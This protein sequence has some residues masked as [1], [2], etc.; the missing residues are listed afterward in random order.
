MNELKFFG[1]DYG[2]LEFEIFHY[3]FVMEQPA[4]I[5]ELYA[6]SLISALAKTLNSTLTEFHINNNNLAE[7]V[8]NYIAAFLLCKNRLQVLNLGDIGTVGIIRISKSL[9]KCSTLIEITHQ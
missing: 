2:N 7:E 8:A 6:S 3:Q 9:Q 4:L 5:Q 1:F